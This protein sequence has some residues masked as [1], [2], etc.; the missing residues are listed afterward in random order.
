MIPAQTSAMTVKAEKLL[1]LSF[2]L[3]PRW[4]MPAGN[5]YFAL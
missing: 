3:S 5:H 1:I 2:P 4:L